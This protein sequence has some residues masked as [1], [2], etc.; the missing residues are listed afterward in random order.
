ME[1]LAHA[2]HVLEDPAP[3]A[4]PT[5]RSSP[6]FQMHSH[7]HYGAPGQSLRLRSDAMSLDAPDYIWFTS[8][9]PNAERPAPPLRPHARLARI[10]ADQSIMIHATS[11]GT[12]DRR[13]LRSRA[14]EDCSRVVPP[15]PR[16]LRLR[17]SLGWVE[18]VLMCQGS[19]ATRIDACMYRVAV[20]IIPENFAG[21]YICPDISIKGPLRR[22]GAAH[23][24][25]PMP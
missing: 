20:S 14:L 9:D 1:G 15:T 19:R 16:V 2:I 8:P 24:R 6:L 21:R 18:G 10:F 3:L 4:P 7:A 22:G 25:S 12:R 17:R 11:A 13:D 5:N 23:V